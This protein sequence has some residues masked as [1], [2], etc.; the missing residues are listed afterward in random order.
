MKKV[1]FRLSLGSKGYKAAPNYIELNRERVGRYDGD[2]WHI[3]KDLNTKLQL[4]RHK[5]IHAGVYN[6]EIGADTTLKQATK[7]LIQR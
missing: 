4:P 6:A 3:F 2:V 5:L 7:T 1:D